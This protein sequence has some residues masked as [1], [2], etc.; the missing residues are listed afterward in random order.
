MKKMSAWLADM[1][2]W[3][4]EI[5]IKLQLSS[6]HVFT[7]IITTLNQ[8]KMSWFV[9]IGF[10]SRWQ[11]SILM[12]AIQFILQNSNV[13]MKRCAY[14]MGILLQANHAKRICFCSTTHLP[15]HDFSRVYL[16]AVIAETPDLV[17]ALSRLLLKQSPAVFCLFWI[18][19][20]RLLCVLWQWHLLSLNNGFVVAHSS[21]ASF[22]CAGTL[23]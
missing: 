11:L 10:F 14:L 9:A 15:V 21:N 5:T 19:V 23:E 22:H 20:D 7:F 12:Q 4:L 8:V 6:C 2:C 16:F 13:L 3:Q 17:C 1:T 18:R